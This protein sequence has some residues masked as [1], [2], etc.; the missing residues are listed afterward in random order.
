MGAE[1]K[2]GFV[3]ALLMWCRTCATTKRHTSGVKER[4]FTG[5]DCIGVELAT[6]FSGEERDT[7]AAA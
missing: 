2:G 5:V 7:A 1:G 6:F 4:C 3:Y